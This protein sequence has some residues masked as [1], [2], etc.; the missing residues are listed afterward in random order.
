MCLLCLSPV[1]TNVACLFM[2]LSLCL[3]LAS[4]VSFMRSYKHKHLWSLFGT[5]QYE[6]NSRKR[7]MTFIVVE[8]IYILS[9]SCLISQYNI[10]S[11]G[12]SYSLISG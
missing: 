12:L 10:M 6:S 2:Y 3:I 11:C 4:Y 7:Q 8:I 9:H 1:Q 5:C